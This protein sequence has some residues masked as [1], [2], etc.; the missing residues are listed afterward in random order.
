MIN[1][2]QARAWFK[3]EIAVEL[4]RLASDPSMEDVVDGRI[5]AYVRAAEH[6]GLGDLAPAEAVD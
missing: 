6:L 4:E 2:E 5:D 3:S 1:D